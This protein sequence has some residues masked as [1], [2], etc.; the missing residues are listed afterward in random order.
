MRILFLFIVLF[1]ARFGFSQINESFSDGDFSQNPSWIGNTSVFKITT[2]FQLQLNDVLA[3][4]S[5]LSTSNNVLG[6]TEWRFFVKHS[7]NSS[8][9][10]LSRVY[11]TSSQSNLTSPLNGYFVEIGNTADNVCLFKQN[12]STETKLIN[13]TNA[14]TSNTTNTINI[15]VIR[16][17][18]GNWELFTDASGGTNFQSE[19]SINDLTFT[20][21]SYFG[22]YCKYTVSNKDKFY[23]DDVYVGPIQVDTTAPSILKVAIINQNSLDVYFSEIVDQNT[24][25][26]LSNYSVSNGINTPSTANLD[27]VNKSLVH[28]NFSTSLVQGSNYVLTVNAINDLAGNTLH[29]STTAFTYYI[30]QM[31]DVVINEIMA[32]P[33]PSVGLPTAEYIE[34]KNTTNFAIPLDNWRIQLG[35]SIKTIS[36]FTIPASGYLIIGNLADSA[37]FSGIGSFVGLSGF[38]LTNSGMQLILMNQNGLMIHQVKYADTWYADNNKKNG[39]WSLEMIDTKNP[40]ACQDNWQASKNSNGGTPSAVNSISS[41]NL[42]FRKPTISRIIFS[43]ANSIKLLFDE[44]MDSLTIKNLM[45]YTVSDGLGNP[46][47]IKA[48]FPDYQSV[49]LSFGLSFLAGIQYKLMIN[50]SL[51]DC[52]GNTM[53]LPKEISFALPQAA[54]VGDLIINEILFEPYT[55]GVDFVEIY[56]ISSKTIDLKNCR[57]ANW[58]VMSQQPINVVEITNDGYLLNAGNFVVLSTNSDKVRQQYFSP[59]ESNFLTIASLPSMSNDAGTISIV[60]S[61]LEPLDYF[62]YSLSMHYPLLKSS[63]GVSLE[64]IRPKSKTQDAG[65]WH[66]AAEAVGFATPGYKNSQ[67]LTELQLQG[68]VLVYPEIFSPD[69]DGF[70]DICSISY[71]FEESGLAANVLIFNSSGQIVRN[72]VRNEMLGNKGVWNWDGFTENR[73]KAPF[74]IYV[75]YIEVFSLNGAVKQFKTSIV[76]GGKL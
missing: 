69:N 48:S 39:G 4:T 68:Q 43:A 12:G 17:N 13:G 64:R 50:D 18:T 61:N 30:P 67:F 76:L 56:N 31:Y 20:N 51:K 24:A 16:S 29:N 72:L 25:N 71:E 37:L 1:I 32:N 22:F 45:A 63:K 57:I 55:D 52:V 62:D 49:E 36:P 58:D 26:T 5:Y 53:L 54:E 15:K 42:D 14:N 44:S 9:N 59:N 60:K 35:T 46:T 7:F 41:T 40:C 23:F 19:G 66:S 73:E 47:F 70:D 3:D 2:A 27:P 74:G 6:E 8:S 11:L 21:T 65:N 28:L 33:I 75:A 10:N 34:L 38:Q